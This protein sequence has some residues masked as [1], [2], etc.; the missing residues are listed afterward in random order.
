MNLHA[1]DIDLGKTIFHLVGLSP[2]IQET[3]AIMFMS[4]G[5]F[6]LDRNDAI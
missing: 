2:S 3:D 6:P 4:P 5:S 1:I